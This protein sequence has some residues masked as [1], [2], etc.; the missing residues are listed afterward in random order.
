MIILPTPS[1]SPLPWGW[2]LVA[3]SLGEISRGCEARGLTFLISWGYMLEAGG[4]W[5]H[6]N[7][8]SLH[9]GVILNDPVFTTG[10]HIA[11]HSIPHQVSFQIF[12][13]TE[14]QSKSWLCSTQEL[15]GPSSG[16]ANKEK[17]E[18]FVGFGEMQ[19]SIR[20]T[21]TSFLEITFWW[22]DTIVIL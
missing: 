13:E 8:A 7:A 16:Q 18:V 9:S 2:G 12:T 11:L 6:Q 20:N 19:F 10:S 14:V 5:P 4:G 21:E 22:Y 17:A 1:S 3:Y 15:P